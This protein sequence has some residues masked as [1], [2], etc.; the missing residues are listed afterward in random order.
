MGGCVL[1]KE[2]Q[3]CMYYLCSVSGELR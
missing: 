3:L 1:Q 2:Y